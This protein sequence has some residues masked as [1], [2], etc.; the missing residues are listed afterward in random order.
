LKSESLFS[1]PSPPSSSRVFTAHIDGGSR[2]NP[3]P[4]AYGVV[5]RNSEGKIIAEL[6]QYLG[7]QTNNFAEYSGLL[8]AL[9]FAQKQNL[10]GLKIV[11]DSELLVKQMKG[12]Y[13]VSSP[14]LKELFDRARRLSGQLQ[15]FS[16]QHV[17]RAYNKDADR[18]VNAALDNQQKKPQQPQA[19]T[20]QVWS[21]P[22]AKD[23]DKDKD[24]KDKEKQSPPEPPQKNSVESEKVMA[25]Q[26]ISSGTQWEPIVGYSRAVRVGNVIHVAG[27][28]ATDADGNIVGVGDAYAQVMQTLRNIES[29][30]QRAGASMKDVVRTRIYVTN[31]AADWEK[32]GKAHG[33]FFSK[34][35]PVTSM[36][37]VSRLINPEML[38]EIE[39]EA[40]IPD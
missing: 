26:N 22:W 24:A 33:E 10:P 19:S 8:A 2:G 38:V 21:P 5:I 23:K 30:L 35:R 6:S 18:L 25:R 32:I 34:I 14:A 29:A 17:L 36:I 7:K 37:E 27:T 31:I 15:H 1:D 3:G 13:R 11:S 20:G 12:Q 4:A 40:I 9:E 16:I 39:A 28:T